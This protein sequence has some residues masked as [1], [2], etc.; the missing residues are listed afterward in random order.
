LSR[1]ASIAASAPL[2]KPHPGASWLKYACAGVFALLVSQY[3]AGW[4]L[5][6]DEDSDVSVAEELMAREQARGAY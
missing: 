6:P 2:P 5:I 3:L 4:L 1:T